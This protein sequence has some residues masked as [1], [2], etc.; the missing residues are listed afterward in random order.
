MS[1][2]RITLLQ[3]ISNFSVAWGYII[4]FLVTVINMKVNNF[5]AES[6]RISVKALLNNLVQSYLG[7]VELQT[8]N[9]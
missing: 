9:N 6:W 1:Y 8:G 3:K 7:T 5:V 4:R 2:K